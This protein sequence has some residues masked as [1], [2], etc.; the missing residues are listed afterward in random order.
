MIKFINLFD[1]DKIKFIILIFHDN[2][3]FFRIIRFRNGNLILNS[4]LGLANGYFK[5]LNDYINYFLNLM[6][7]FK[8]YF[9]LSLHYS[10]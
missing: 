1:L 2:C 3:I 4:F 5:I 8:L 10:Q 9:Y 6:Q 7:T